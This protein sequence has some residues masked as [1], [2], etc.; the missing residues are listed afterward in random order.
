MAFSP[1]S[2][3]PMATATPSRPTNPRDVQVAMVAKHTQVLRSRTWERLK[4]EVE[5]AQQKGTTA[6]CYLIQ[7]DRTG[8]ID[9]P[10]ESFTEIFLQELCK[11]VP[12]QQLD[13]II[14]NHVNPNRMATLKALMDI[15]PQVRIVCSKPAV[16][17][18]QSA[19][20]EWEDQWSQAFQVVRDGDRLDLGQG[21]TLQFFSVKTPRWP[22]GLCTYD[23]KTQILFSDK[24]YGM[25]V[26][27]DEI[28]DEQWQDLDGGVPNGMASRQRRYYF[29]C[30]HAPQVRQ[31]DLALQKLDRVTSRII[32]PGHGPLV[33]YHVSQVRRDYRQW[34][35]AQAKQR[36]R[37]AVLYASAY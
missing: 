37:V 34:C 21:H 3:I 20:P 15:A 9:P 1:T 22:D 19:F 7:A 6:N 14:L 11:Q 16:R 10:G 23:A 17:A 32:A 28:L 31:V 8:L 4:F 13:D 2:A 29:D 18:I 27:G 30:L 24:F 33:Q 36:F 25:H 5:Y 35:Q 26:C 12:L